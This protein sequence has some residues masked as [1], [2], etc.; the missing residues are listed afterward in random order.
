M[1]VVRLHRITLS[2]EDTQSLIKGG[3]SRYAKSQDSKESYT[4]MNIVQYGV[5]A[6]SQSS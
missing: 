3:Y 4:E 5:K 1:C 6:S 2:E